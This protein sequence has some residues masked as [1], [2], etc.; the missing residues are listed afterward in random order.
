[1][2]NFNAAGFTDLR[3]YIT[4]MNGWTHVALIDDAGNEETR[5]DIHNDSRASW[6]DASANPTDLTIT[7]SGSDSDIAAPV[8]LERAELHLSSSST[9]TMHDG[10]LQGEINGSLQAAAV[11]IGS[12]TDE[13]TVTY[14]VELPTQ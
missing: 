10:P 11:T 8:T 4:S 6:G 3:Q 7:L 2:S 1:M 13:G 14:T 12:D 5:I 9:T